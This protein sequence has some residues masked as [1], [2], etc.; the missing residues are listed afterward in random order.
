MIA[1]KLN[2]RMSFLQLSHPCSFIVSSIVSLQKRHLL[3]LVD[4]EEAEKKKSTNTFLLFPRFTPSPSLVQ[5]EQKGMICF[6]PAFW[7]YG[8]QTYLSFQGSSAGHEVF[9]PS[10]V[11]AWLLWSY[12]SSNKGYF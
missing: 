3:S 11:V 2:T 4:V 10:V 7:S 8:F 9:F 5:A 6:P 12:S 1:W